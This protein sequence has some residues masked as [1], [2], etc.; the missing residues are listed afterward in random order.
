MYLLENSVRNYAWGS[1]TTISHALGRE[2]SGLPE[3]ELWIGAHPSAPSRT[4]DGALDQ[5]IA[6]DPEHY[7]G[8]LSRKAFGDR[9]PFLAKLLAADTAL[10][11]QVHPTL[12]QA[13]AGFAAENAAGIA[14]D[15]PNRN[16][17]D[18]N[19][20]PEMFLAL[21]NFQALCGFRPARHSAALF[22]TLA[23]TSVALSGS[24][25]SPLLSRVAGLLEAPE[26]D[27]P[28]ALRAAFEA[29]IGGGS[30]VAVAVTQ[31]VDAASALERVL[32]DSEESAGSVAQTLRELAAM[33]PADPGVLISLMLNRVSLRPG[34]CLA[35]PAG[36]VHAYLCGFGVEVMAASDNVLRGGLTPKHIDIPELLDTVDFRSLPVPRVTPER[37]SVGQELYRPGF[38]EF[39]VQ[40]ITAAAGAGPVSL[41]QHGPLLVLVLEGDI[42]LNTPQ[43][44]LVLGS[45][46]SAIVPA[47]EA[48][49]IL[50]LPNGGEQDVLAFAITTA[51]A[52]D[53]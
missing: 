23:E 5:L 13:Q 50:H 15:A 53:R 10:S 24:R 2:P 38:A 28:V 25:T 44:D 19:H 49:T 51:L 45:G 46:Q 30:E 34:E 52:E 21:T 42:R 40:Q 29:L 22:R 4:A 35:L 48:P 47:A 6:S 36:N 7:L 41:L 37:I 43:G 33:Y 12:A 26:S 1:R 14:Q 3:A 27:E 39:Q 11:L 32:L 17:K 16:Y 31:A 9:L 8:S 18:D 20:K